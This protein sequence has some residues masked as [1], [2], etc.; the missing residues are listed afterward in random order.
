MKILL[1]FTGQIARASPA[2]YL[3]EPLAGLRLECLRSCDV[4]LLDVLRLLSSGLFFFRR[5]AW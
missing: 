2:S 3:A 5:S 1:K 4:L